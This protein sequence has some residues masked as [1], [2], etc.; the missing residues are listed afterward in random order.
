MAHIHLS[1]PIDSNNAGVVCV[2]TDIGDQ[3]L[4]PEKI[5]KPIAMLRESIQT[6]SPVSQ[7]AIIGVRL[8]E[9]RFMAKYKE[10][11]TSIL[12]QVSHQPIIEVIRDI[13]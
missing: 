5:P 10:S 1:Y 9:R 13:A 2:T 12:C 6:I 11:V 7:T 8:R 4:F 3:L